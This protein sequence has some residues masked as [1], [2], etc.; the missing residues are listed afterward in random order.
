M[1]MGHISVDTGYTTLPSS[2]RYL[3]FPVK[4]GSE[5]YKSYPWLSSA[6]PVCYN[7]RCAQ[8]ALCEGAELRP[9]I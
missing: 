8:T 5:L 4:E 2:E 6:C 3:F 7:S 9:N 1:S